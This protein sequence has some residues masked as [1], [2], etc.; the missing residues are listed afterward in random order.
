MSKSTLAESC[1]RSEERVLDT[2]REV[3]RSSV[4]L[5]LE[6]RDKHVCESEIKI[7]EIWET[8]SSPS[9]FNAF[10]VSFVPI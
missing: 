8:L 9:V 4:L 3:E 10:T 2:M 6:Q 7:G 5:G 1:P